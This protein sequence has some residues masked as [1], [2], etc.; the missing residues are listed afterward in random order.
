MMPDLLSTLPTELLLHILLSLSDLKALYAAI[1]SSP[2]LHA[3]FRLN[4]HLVFR[5]AISRSLPDDLASPVLVYML[6]RERL[7]V[8]DICA[9]LTFEQ[10]RATVKDVTTA[11]ETRPWHEI[12][13]RT[14]FHT[15]AQAIRIHDIA[16][17]I[18]RCKLDYFG[19]LKFEKLADSQYRYDRPYNATIHNPKGVPMDVHLPLSNPSWAEETR[20]IRLLWLLAAGWRASGYVGDSDEIT[21]GDMSRCQQEFLSLEDQLIR[22]SAFELTQ[23]MLP[24]PV[25]RPPHESDQETVRTLDILQPYPIHIHDG[26]A[27]QLTLIN[28]LP[29]SVHFDWVP[30]SLTNELSDESFPFRHSIFSMLSKNPERM[31]VWV[32]TLRPDSPL[33]GAKSHMFDCLGFG[34]WEGRRVCLEL[35]LYAYP[36]S[37][38]KTRPK[39]DHNTLT[40]YSC[41][42]SDRFF[43]L[44]KIYQQQDEREQQGWHR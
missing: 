11:A 8:K 1:L 28:S 3:V 40:R 34:F 27:Q 33:Q 17:S 44:S 43:R 19:T 36:Q 12:S 13:I 30:A 22:D 31:R 41:S 18:L 21:V 29:T 35:G 20:A 14:I 5:T 23:S 25:L 2:H 26:A 10:F 39:V 6:L 37:A 4:A 42:D 9:G 7:A 38:S 15:I 32:C 24:G 16:F